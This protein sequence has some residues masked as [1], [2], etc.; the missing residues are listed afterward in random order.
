M[1]KVNTAPVHYSGYPNS[2]SPL[3]F[4]DIL[5]GRPVALLGEFGRVGIIG[6]KEV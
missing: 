3:K 4:W 1:S 2:K 6:Q 5:E